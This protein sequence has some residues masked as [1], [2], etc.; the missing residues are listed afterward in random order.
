M[1]KNKI[2]F[3]ICGAEF[4]IVTNDSAAYIHALATETE[5][6]IQ[7]YITG[8]GV[9]SFQAAV[10]T[11]MEYGDENRRKENILANIKT[12]VQNHL[13]DAARIRAERDRYK[14]EYEKLLAQTKDI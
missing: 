11:A 7:K 14:A 13:D 4:T 12:Q 6:R 2:S 8:A 3:R 5:T 10:L 1:E 9:S